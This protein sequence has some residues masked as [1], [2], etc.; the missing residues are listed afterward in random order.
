VTVLETVARVRLSG[1]VHAER[2]VPHPSLPLIAALDS[3]RPAV[4]VW[5][6]G[7]GEPREAG[8]IGGESAAYGE[9]KS[10]DRWKLTPAVAWHP[11]EP[12]LLIASG[13]TATRW[14]RAGTSR[15]DGLPPGAAYRNL[16][17]SPDGSSLWASPSALPEEDPWQY[18]ADVID[19]TSGTA[20]AGRGWDTGIVAHPGGGLVTAL[21]SDQGATLVLFA[22]VDQ[23]S[24]PTR[25]RVQRKALILDADG[26]KAPVFSADGR[27]FAIRGNAYG[28]T[29]AVFEFPSLTRTL[30][31]LLC[32]PSPGFPYPQEWRDRMHAWSR[33]NIAFGTQPGALWIGTPEGELLEVDF[34]AERM[35]AHQVLDGSRVTALCAAHWGGLLAATADGNL[36]SISVTASP[37]AA[38]RPGNGTPPDL[39]AAFLKDTCDVPPDGR[40]EDHLVLTDGER[41]WGQD[42][43]E[44]VT[45]TTSADPSW[46]QIQAAVNNYKHKELAAARDVT[47]SGAGRSGGGLM[48]RALSFIVII[49]K[50]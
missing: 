14:T 26:Y 39:I 33:H 4:H 32:D 3:G 42:D 15:L 31:T 16:A 35:V 49:E 43:L 48:A 17:F 30:T 23:D 19:L 9:A 46:L 29:L 21:Q 25:M 36:T 8:I 44:T 13:G 27:H 11:D 10:W 20:H 28:Q 6:Y 18:C 37:E 22:R 7:E 12:V 47:D 38:Q 1:G 41:T 2:L 45:S 34:L 5:D 24:G 40:L 50:R